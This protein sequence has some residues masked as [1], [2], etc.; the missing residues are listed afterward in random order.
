MQKI[1]TKELMMTFLSEY[2]DKSEYGVQERLKS[3]PHTIKMYMTNWS[4]DRKTLEE[5]W[6]NCWAEYFSNSRSADFLR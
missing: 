3:I 2:S 6:V 5:E 1:N 4:E